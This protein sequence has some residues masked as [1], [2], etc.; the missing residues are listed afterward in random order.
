MPKVPGERGKMKTV[1]LTSDSHSW[2]LK[3]FFHQWK[4]YALYG[5]PDKVEV[6]GFTKPDLPKDIKFHSIGDMKDYP[7]DKWSNALIKY[8]NEIPDDLV[9]ILLE[10]YWLI[11]PIDYDA[12]EEAAE[13][14]ES[15]KDVI[16]FDLTTDRCN[17]RNAE[18]AGAFRKLD[19]CRAKG[20]Y[21]LSFQ[22]SIYRKSLLLEVLQ[23][24]ESPWQ[25]ELNGSG[26]LNALPYDVLGCYSWPINYAI[27]V[28]K[29]KFDTEGRWMYPP[30]TLTQADWRELDDL[31]YTGS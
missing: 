23:P 25:A 10:D 21:S 7:V 18:Y 2:L 16:R 3:G 1:V 28:N 13:L 5:G 14:M 9:L 17:N 8:L 20:D 31:G 22:A 26:R 4:K 30:R 15:Y 11:R 19:L 24:N 12:V 6:A 29:G 27:V